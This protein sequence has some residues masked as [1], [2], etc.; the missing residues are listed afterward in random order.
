MS[1]VSLW[2]ANAACARTLAD[3]HVTHPHR[4]RQGRGRPLVVLDP[5]CIGLHGT[6]EK[7]VVLATGLAVRQRIEAGHRYRVAMTRTGDEFIALRQRVVFAQQ[8]HAV[9]FISLHANPARNHR[10]HGASMYRF[11]YRASD[12]G[13]AR[14][15]ERENGAGLLP[16][17]RFGRMP[18][19]VADSLSS[20][21]RRETGLHSSVPQAS[22]VGDLAMRTAL[23]PDPARHAHFA[24]C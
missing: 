2:A 21:M 13:S 9:L 12:L 1:A 15:A 6:R 7:D 20:L 18:P 19:A 10:V 17:P 11:A 22:M 23:L 8:H 24:A 14:L 5:G 16:G 3:H 4:V